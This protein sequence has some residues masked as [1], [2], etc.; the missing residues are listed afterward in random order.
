MLRPLPL[1]NQPQT[2]LAGV[3]EPSENAS[4]L[5]AVVQLADGVSLMLG[6][7]TPKQAVLQADS[8]DVVLVGS[9]GGLHLLKPIGEYDAKA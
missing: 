7:A 8:Q 1:V 5:I 3:A 4:R 2:R 9:N 6:V